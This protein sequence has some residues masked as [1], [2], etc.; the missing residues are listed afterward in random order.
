MRILLIKSRS[1]ASKVSGINPPLGLLMLAAWLRTRM[2]AD[3]AVLDL[4]FERDPVR[5]VRAHVAAFRPHLVG[6]SALTPEAELARRAARAVK[7]VDS[8]LPVLLGGPHATAFGEEALEERAF[9]VAVL[10]EGEETLLEL[11]RLV[12][13]EGARWKDPGNLDAVRGIAYR[14]WEAPELPVR[15]TALRPFIQ[16]LDALPLPAWDLIDL[17]RYWA[18]PSM[19]SIGVRP[20]VPIFTSRGCPF[21][22]IYCHNLFG[23]RFR[24]RSVASVLDELSWIRRKLGVADLEV[25]DDIA[26]FD[27]PRWRELLEALSR[28]GPRWT[29]NFPNALRADLLEPEE[30]VAL[31]RAGAG[32]VSV[33]IETASPRLQELIGKEL[34]CS[35]AARAIEGLARQRILTRGFFMAGFPTETADELYA[36]MK[37]A[38]DSPLH[39]ALFFTVNPFRGTK[40]HE[41]C[42]Q[43]GRL[44][45]RPRSIDYEYYGAPFNASEIPE[46]RFRLMVRTAYARFYLDPVRM[47][48]IARDRPYRSDIPLRA[49]RVFTQ[50]ASFRRVTE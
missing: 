33:A 7:M 14:A 29:V 42:R 3:V 36:T 41:L 22:C 23:K 27:R 13:S 20:Y 6:I 44:P 26:N 25:L 46:A 2:R 30:I 8:A 39:L 17:K 31:K 15:R 40:L 12:A 48:R 19:A 5:A 4:K 28:N 38:W 21:R 47:A 16:D 11:A 24:C 32:E 37:F 50:L 45:E 34:D 18:F 49:W 1:L 43:A 35:R 10:G 9:D